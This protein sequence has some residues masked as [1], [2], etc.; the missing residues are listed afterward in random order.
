MIFSLFEGNILKIGKWRIENL[1]KNRE[2]IF[3]EMRYMPK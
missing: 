2:V 1:K 3:F